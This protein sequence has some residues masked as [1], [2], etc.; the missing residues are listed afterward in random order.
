MKDKNAQAMG[1]KR[2]KGTTKKKRSEHARMM[3]N[4]KWATQGIGMVEILKKEK[5]VVAKNMIKY[6]DGFIKL[7]GKALIEAD[8]INTF[9]VKDTF[10][11]IWK[12]YLNK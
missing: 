11:D 8:N 1:K 4:K 9:L 12:E 7:L 10:S 6:G 2:W 3:A 5:I